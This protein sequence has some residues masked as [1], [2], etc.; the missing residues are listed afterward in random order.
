MYEVEEHNRE[1]VTEECRKS[2]LY[3]V[4]TKGETNFL[5]EPPCWKLYADH[6]WFWLLMDESAISASPI[7]ILPSN[8][9]T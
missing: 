1:D 9:M 8:N 6:L 4:K 7:W 2:H 5:T 3:I